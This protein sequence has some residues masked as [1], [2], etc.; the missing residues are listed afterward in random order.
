[1]RLSWEQLA[2]QT[3]AVDAV[4]DVFA[5]GENES[6]GK[7]AFLLGAETVA[8]ELAMDE[9]RIL[10]NVRAIQKRNHIEKADRATGFEGCAFSVEMETGTGKT[11]VYLKT[12]LALAA[13]YGLKK[14]IILVPS[15]A[16]REGV[17]K[18]LHD[19]REH[20]VVGCDL[21]SYAAFT[22]DSGRLGEVRDFAR[23]SGVTIMLTTIQ[24]FNKDNAVLNRRDLDRF[25]GD[26]PIEMLAATRPVVVMDEPQNM[27]TE[28]A[29][30]SIG[31]LCPLFELRYSATH[32][33]KRHLVYALGPAEALQRKLV[34]SID[35]VGLS[36]TDPNRLPFTVRAVTAKKG[37]PL[38]ARVLLEAKKADGRFEMREVVLKKL[39]D[40]FFKSGKN[41]RYAGLVVE[42]IDKRNESVALSDT[43]MF[44]VS[45]AAPGK[46]SMFRA[47]I[48]E[49]IRAH[50]EKQNALPDVK[51]LSLFFID[52]VDNYIH[53]ES[54]LRK[55]FEEEFEA[56][57]G[58]WRGFSERV[59]REVHGGYFTKKGKTGDEVI[60]T[61]GKT[62]RDKD[63]FDLIMRDKE[64]LL[65]FSEPVCFVFSHSALRE[66][67]D[68]P[69][70]FQIC[71]LQETRSET[72]KRQK[73]GRGLR[74]PVDR[75]GAR[76]AGG[77]ASV[78][79]VIANESY[80]QYVREL[81]GEY[82]AMGVSAPHAPERRPKKIRVRKDRLE[83]EAFRALWERIKHRTRYAIDFSGE[84]LAE[85]AARAFD[86]CVD[87]V[88]SLAI[89]ATTV[90][91][92]MRDAWKI[93]PVFVRAPEAVVVPRT[94]ALVDDVA[95]RIA[96]ETGI[97]RKTAL[98]FL[99]R[100]RETGKLGLLF[101]NPEEFVRA[102]VRIVSG[103]L[104]ALVINDGLRY[105]K[106][107]DA[108]EMKLFSD[109]ET[110]DAEKT[111]PVEK[112]LFDTVAFDSEGERDFAA[113][114]D[115]R[116]DVRL[117]V[118]LPARFCVDTPL[119]KYEPDWAIVMGKETEEKVYLVRET[120][121]GASGA[122]RQ[123]VLGNLRPEEGQ[124]I[125]CGKKHFATLG[126]DFDV[127]TNGNF[128]RI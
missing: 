94:N 24:S 31:K 104:S 113:S 96:R 128:V 116:D 39:D 79:T 89:V 18:A 55:I 35:V 109:F 57:K 91:L 5:Y 29:K 19:L 90:R 53:A 62:A 34:K 77:G 40:V 100:V 73:I 42:S 38:K 71:T 115:A 45:D 14:F 69:N 118:K 27:V 67:W 44:R 88:P 3:Q 10:A 16:I 46:E 32:K 125:F 83:S 22:Y 95:Q 13:R 36:Y 11:Y 56:A 8:N 108:W 9:T 66:G 105:E 26:V 50:I 64:R 43:R 15:V 117:F 4:S 84:K 99:R 49:T 75:F 12:I 76:L 48:R 80:E 122:S 23:S 92:T 33:E 72:D 37:E 102:C 21:P 106:T 85:E 81:Q 54:V 107:G 121:F 25:H 61:T 86:E 87:D 120:K 41:D 124:K 110:V 60:D 126:V 119:G 97:T 52:R 59:A 111:I 51:V 82:R 2:Y 6:T 74:L 78:L 101:E 30:F 1:M 112:S 58:G 93:S 68:N 70:I 123:D 7:E 28:L 98:S 47:Q 114:L 103:S 65:S 63:A 127:E 17:S 20:F